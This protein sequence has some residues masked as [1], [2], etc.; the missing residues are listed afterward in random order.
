MK[1]ADLIS[2]VLGFVAGIAATSLTFYSGILDREVR[3]REV[4]VE[5]MRVAF[6]VLKLPIEQT[7]TTYRRWSCEVLNQHTEPDLNCSAEDA[8]T[9]VLGDIA[10]FRDFNVGDRDEGS[11]AL[12]DIGIYVCET[13]DEGV[14]QL[15]AAALRRVGFGDIALRRW[16]LY[17]EI[18]REELSNEVTV[19]Y[20]SDHPEA[21]EVPRIIDALSAP[22][23]GDVVR[24]ENEGNL[25][26]WFISV[27]V[28]DKNR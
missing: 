17:D 12:T 5:V 21:A 16:V 22:V 6:E 2:P 26:R 1:K 28:C 20:D 14:A 3:D 8:T 9:A 13:S 25:S 19:I 24:H 15:A 23:F 7:G 10:R 27:V 11:P 4:D 18:S